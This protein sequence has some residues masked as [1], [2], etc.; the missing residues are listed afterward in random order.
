M[1]G[2]RG[3][4]PLWPASR[5]AASAVVPQPARDAD[6]VE[7]RA[8]HALVLGMHGPQGSAPWGPSP[9]STLALRLAGTVLA[10]PYC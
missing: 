3:V 4:E 2:N 1:G 9:G 5:P 10:P 7:P 6:R 8:H